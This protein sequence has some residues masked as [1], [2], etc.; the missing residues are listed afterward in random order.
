LTTQP[1]CARVQLLDRTV[2]GQ[3]IYWDRTFTWT[4][5][6]LGQNIYWDRTFTG[7]EQL[8]NKDKELI[9]AFMN[10]HKKKEIAEELKKFMPKTWKYSL[11]IRDH[12][13]I[14]MTIRSA[15]VDLVKEHEAKRAS[16]L[17][18][19]PNFI[20]RT[21]R[22]VSIN[23]HIAD[24]SFTESQEMINKIMAALNLNNFDHSDIQSDYFHV[25][26]YVAVN[27][28]TYDKPFEVKA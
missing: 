9:V 2:T 22:Y 12:Y 18:N 27:I 17:S 26:H 20:P 4:E 23:P 1:I 24:E 19:H 6:L 25:G 21:E 8:L 3:N 10:Q 16:K 15:P 13:T 28:G 14:A 11:R 5:H 7:T